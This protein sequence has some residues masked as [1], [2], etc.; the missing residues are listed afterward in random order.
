[1]LSTNRRIA[2]L[3]EGSLDFHFGKTA[4]S[5]LR[6]QP[7]SVVCVIDRDH[8]GLTAQQVLGLGGAIPVCANVEEALRL[9]PTELLIGI[10][11]RG[12]GLPDSWR[13]E[14]LRALS[15]GLD[16]VSGL[17]FMLGEDREF[18]AAAQRHGARILD[19]RK[20]PEGLQVAR[21][22]ARR[23]GACVVTFVGSDC[24]VG[25]MTAALEMHAAAARMG[26]RSSFVATGQTG[27]M[28]AGHGIAVDRV[29]G[30]F[31]AGALEE[32]VVEAAEEA[33]LVF[34]E[35]QGSLLHPGYSGVTLALIHGSA[36]DAMV[37]VH[38]PSRRSID[39]Y[40][41][42]IPP[43]DRLITIYEEAA[44]WVKPARV[45]A[46]ALNTRDLDPGGTETAI[47]DAE[48]LTGLPAT[49]PVKFGGERLVQA[50]IREGAV[51]ALTG[52][53]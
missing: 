29:I 21:L 12:G 44:G 50:L 20:S 18:Q 52:K 25:K 30:D 10:A 13:A 47:R 6:Y 48:A 3:A 9:D 37:L 15:S 1:M 26:V 24:A 28:L 39:G 11:P 49:D 38:P 41:L 40:G 7:E 42:P 34:V 27:I 31:M 19:V 4:I 51:S 5:I 35:G 23:P 17:H 22:R 45:A 36:P 53:Q 16:V 46:I 2:V 14:I 33:D 32:L 43:L 8:A